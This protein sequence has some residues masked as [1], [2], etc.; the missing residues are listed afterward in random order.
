MGPRRTAF[1]HGTRAGWDPKG[2][3]T[4][5]SAAACVVPPNRRAGRA[6]LPPDRGAAPTAG[7]SRCSSACRHRGRGWFR[8]DAVGRVPGPAICRSR[9]SDVVALLQPHPGPVAGR[10]HAG[11]VRRCHHHFPFSQLLC[12]AV[13]ESRAGGPV[14]SSPGG[15]VVLA[16]SRAGA[17]DGCRGPWRRTF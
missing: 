12:Q 3:V 14:G 7:F 2:P 17:T 16:G 4:V 13:P 11:E 8:Q 6:A 9:P 10:Q 1:P 5:V 15:C